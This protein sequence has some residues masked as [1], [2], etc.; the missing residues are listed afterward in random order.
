LDHSYREL[1]PPAHLAGYLRCVWTETT[2]DRPEEPGVLVLP[3][4]CIDIVWVAGSPPRVAGPAT[5]PAFP[6]IPAGSTLVGM[7][8]HP[9]MASSALG[10]PANKL[11]NLDLPLADLWGNDLA[12]PDGRFHDTGL[13]ED[14]FEAIQA[15]LSRCLADAEP[16]DDLVKAAAGWV[17]RHPDSSLGRLADLTGLSDRHLRR[18]FEAAVGYGPKTFQRIVRFQRW[19]SLTRST[20]EEQRRLT[21]LAAKAGYADQSHLTREVSRL[22]GLPPATLLGTFETQPA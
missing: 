12:R 1:A 7:R 20:P 21:D 2:S 17:A 16:G 5:L 19:L 10:V 11:E 6:S 4:G 9:G 18:R 14:G 15:L 22:A 13:A 3:D 8:F